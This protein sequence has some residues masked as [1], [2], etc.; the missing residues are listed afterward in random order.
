[1]KLLTAKEVMKKTTLSRMTIWRYIQDGNFPKSIKLG[2]QRI[3]W[4][5]DD[6]DKWIN[7]RDKL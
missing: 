4:I 3:A 5:E 7:E 6:I 2:P 1:M